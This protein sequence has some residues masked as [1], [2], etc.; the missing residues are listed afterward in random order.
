MARSARQGS[1]SIVI[2]APPEK[3]WSRLAELDRMGDWSPE[4][5][6]VRWLDGASSPARPGA[7]FVGR[8][9]YGWLRWSMACQV[10]TADPGR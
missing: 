10:Q 3:V 8:N 2:D 5:L 7:R 9:R 4:C 1:V 6:E